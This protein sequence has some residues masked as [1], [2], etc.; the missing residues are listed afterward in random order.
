L[1]MSCPASLTIYATLALAL[2][3]IAADSRTTIPSRMHAMQRAN[4]CAADPANHQSAE[5]DQTQPWPSSFRTRN[6]RI[7]SVFWCWATAYREWPLGAIAAQAP[8]PGGQAIDGAGANGASFVPAHRDLGPIRWLQVEAIPAEI[9]SS[10][11]GIGWWAVIQPTENRLMTRYHS[12]W[13]FLSR[14]R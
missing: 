4:G 13:P 9:S 10:L 8:R 6:Q 5:S 11:P 7:H 3:L 1:K 12:S 2:P 14:S